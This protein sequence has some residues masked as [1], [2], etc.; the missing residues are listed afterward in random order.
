MTL[1]GALAIVVALLFFSP[2]AFADE[3][4]APWQKATA[5]WKDTAVDLQKS[6]LLGIAPHV[7]ALEQS[8]KEA[9]A[10]FPPHPNADGSVTIL[11]D[12]LAETIAAMAAAAQAKQTSKAVL[13]PY[14]IISLALGS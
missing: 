14:P 3:S 4:M 11:T 5:A 10:D 13:N 12:G 8:L 2:T 7:E 9:T 6:G 1:R